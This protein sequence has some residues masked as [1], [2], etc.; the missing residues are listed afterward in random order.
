MKALKFLNKKGHSLD[1]IDITEQAPTKVEL[2]VMLKSYDGELKKLFNTSG[3]AYRELKIKDK[4]A[5][6]SKDQAFKMLSANGRLVKR[7]FVIKGKKGLVGF[8]EKEWKQFF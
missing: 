3:V 6:M 2:E 5:D 1:P 7:P 8:K 4:I